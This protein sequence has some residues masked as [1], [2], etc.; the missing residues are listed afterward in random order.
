MVAELEKWRC[1]LARGEVRRSE[2]W[3]STAGSVLFASYRRCHGNHS[4]LKIAGRGRR[5]RSHA[6]AA[7]SKNFIG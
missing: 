1:G 5:R 7:C 2:S 4:L 6:A 3:F